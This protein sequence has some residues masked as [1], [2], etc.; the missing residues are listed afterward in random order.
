PRSDSVM[1]GPLTPSNGG[2][3]YWVSVP[4][5]YGGSII[6]HITQ[7]R[8]GGGGG[9][10]IDRFEQIVGS[11]MSLHLANADGGGP[12]ISLG[13]ASQQTAGPVDVRDRPSSFAAS[14]AAQH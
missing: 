9:A 11:D 5:R 2:Y 6:G 14:A 4:V 12:W 7:R 13:D 1:Y 8:I 3:A 10:W